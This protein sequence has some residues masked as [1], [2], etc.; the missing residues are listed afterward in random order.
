MKIL[1]SVFA[2]FIALSGLI[3][4]TIPFISSGMQD[5]IKS[6]LPAS[7]DKTIQLLEQKQLWVQ[8]GETKIVL[9]IFVTLLFL[10]LTTS[11]IIWINNKKTSCS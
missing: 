7:E 11:V 10:F 1:K 9:Y 4:I 3:A 2:I 6:Q 8:I 5:K